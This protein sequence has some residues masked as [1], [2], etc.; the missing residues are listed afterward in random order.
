[1]FRNYIPRPGRREYFTIFLLLFEIAFFGLFADNF[2]S[3]DNLTR[4]MQNASE[5]AIVSIGMTMVIIL[6]GID[7]SVGAVLGIVAIIVGN[8]VNSGVNP[9]LITLIAVIAGTLLG[10]ING[11]IIGVMKIPPIIAT[12]ATMNI[13]RAVVFGM[14]G[15]AWLTGLPPVFN[16]LTTSKLLGIPLVFYIVIIMYVIF[17]YIFTFRPFGRHL[18]AIGTNADA[19]T[20]VGINSTRVK[21]LSHAILGGVVGIAAI[22]YVARMGS[23]EMTIGTD[24]PLQSIAAVIIGGTAITG[25]RGSLVGTLAGVLFITFM[26]NGIVIFGVPSLWE[27]AIIG[28]LIIISVTMDLIMQKQSAR[29]KLTGNLVGAAR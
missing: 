23:V 19:A 4:V 5:L 14:L 28:L 25:G 11:L 18:Y 16:S 6:G 29:R 20:L 15:G 22:M 21:I 7:L 26:K 9:L 8:L 1:M 3:A 2:F 27:K 17:Y 10:L 24:L 13:G 12:L